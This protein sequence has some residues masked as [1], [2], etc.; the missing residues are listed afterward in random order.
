[1]PVR[2]ANSMPA[3]W[4]APPVPEMAKFTVPGLAL[5]SATSSRT[6]LAGNAGLAASRCGE[7]A[8]STT[9]AKSFTGSNGSC[10][11]TLGAMASEPMSVSSSVSPSGGDFAT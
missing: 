5:A 10:G 8:T 4:L 1:M 11:N 2:S 9:G 6:L 7:Y 3:R